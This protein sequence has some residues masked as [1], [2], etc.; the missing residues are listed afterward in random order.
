MHLHIIN[1][2]HLLSERTFADISQGS[3]GKV[4]FHNI[5]RK[6][7]FQI[8]SDNVDISYDGLLDIEVESITFQEGFLSLMGKLAS[9]VGCCMSLFLTS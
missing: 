9:G 1:P 2:A 8:H 7:F 3:H 6:F 5:S 4:V